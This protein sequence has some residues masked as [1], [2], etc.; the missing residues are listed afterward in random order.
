M[1]GSTFPEESA[2]SK[3][4]SRRRLAVLA[5]ASTV[6][7]VA[8][9]AAAAPAEAGIAR[10]LISEFHLT[11]GPGQE[12]SASVYCP[13]GWVATGGGGLAF[14]PTVRIRSSYPR[15]NDAWYVTAKNDSGV[16]E[17]VNARVIC[18]LGIPTFTRSSRRLSVPAKGIVQATAVCPAGTQSV[19]GGYLVE[20]SGVVINT[21]DVTDDGWRARAYNNATS[22]GY[23]TAYATCAGGLPAR[24]IPESFTQVDLGEQA[25]PVLGCNANEFLTGGAFTKLSENASNVITASIPTEPGVWKW[26]YKNLDGIPYSILNRAICIPAG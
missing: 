23:F 5:I 17:Q 19:G 3:R 22:T 6:G 14:N 13:S 9:L 12:L 10:T 20:T 16:T 2:P 1:P 24:R 25:F 11:L 21:S 7:L 18:A 8:T 26:N 4:R 15:L